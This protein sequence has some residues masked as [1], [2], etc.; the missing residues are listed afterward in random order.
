VGEKRGD[1]GFRGGGLSRINIEKPYYV[2]RQNNHRHGK[3]VTGRK[4]QK[5]IT[6]NCQGL[7]RELK[8]EVH[9]L[10]EVK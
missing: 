10:R 8:V 9:N 3:G 4:D 2:V 7:R 6:K 5:K 1:F